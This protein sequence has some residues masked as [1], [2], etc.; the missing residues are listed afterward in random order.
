M[1][2]GALQPAGCLYKKEPLSR[3]CSQP[4]AP[5]CWRIC[6]PPHDVSHRLIGKDRPVCFSGPSAC[7]YVCMYV[8]SRAPVQRQH[9][10]ATCVASTS[11]YE[12][13]A[14]LLCKRLSTRLA[15]QCAC[16]RPPSPHRINYQTQS[17]HPSSPTRAPCAFHFPFIYQTP[18]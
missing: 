10:S 16:F 8:C 12:M 14:P 5:N 18:L 11:T 3:G 6:S 15:R 13:C 7:M 4:K 2:T 1:Y 17:H 9:A